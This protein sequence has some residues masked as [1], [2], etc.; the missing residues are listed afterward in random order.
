LIPIVGFGQKTSSLSEVLWSRVKACHSLFEDMDDDGIPDFDKIDDSKNGY[1]KISG[2]WPTCG[3]SC[4]SIVGAYKNQAG[5]YIILQSDQVPCGWERKVSSS[6]DLNEILPSNF[7]ISSFISG[8]ISEKITNPIFFIDFEIPQIGT[9]TKLTIELVPFG[10]KPD[11]NELLCFDFKEKEGYKNCKSIYGI[12][13]IAEG[14][15]DVKTLDYVLSGDFTKISPADKSVIGKAIGKDDS[16]FKSKESIQQH[17]RELKKVYNVYMLL[18]STELTLGWDKK[19]SRFFIKEKGK[20][21]DKLTFKD[22]LIKNKYWNPR[23]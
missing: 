18:E 21:P 13:E 10:L 17:L 6:K 11:G 3:C 23:C 14:I 1:L 16:R 8:Q 5:E 2:S 22:F 20:K 15:R 19:Y 12:K 9:D 4:T 7:G